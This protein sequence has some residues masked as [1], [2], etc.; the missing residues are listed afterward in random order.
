MQADALSQFSKDYVAD[1]EDNRQVQVLCP[2]QFLKAAQ[3]HF[4]PEKDSLA[5]RIRNASQ[6]EAS[7]IEGLKSIEK[8]SPKALTDGTAL[9]EEDD[10][11]VYYK[12]KLYVP[13][14]KKS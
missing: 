10:G 3:K 13:L 14:C 9:W 7:V 11:L 5:E 6:R 12:G 1:K 8:F 2:V 4:K